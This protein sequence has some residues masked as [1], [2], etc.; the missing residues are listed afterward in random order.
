MITGT[1]EG[2]HAAPHSLLHGLDFLWLEITEKCNLSCTHCYA[3]SGPHLP[4]E[5]K[6]KFNDWR[7]VMDQAGR[8]GCRGV[9]FIG[10]EPTI[11]PDLS[12]LVRHAG[13]AGFEFCEV[14][15]NA[16]ALRS[17]LLKTLHDCG[18]RVA[19]SIY[20][21]TAEVHDRIT[22]RG[23]SFDRT[24]AG[25]RALVE[26]GIPTRAA[27][28]VM[29][30]NAAYVGETMELL[31][32]IGVDTMGTDVVRGLGRGFDR[33]PHESPEGEL[34]GACWQGRLC[35]DSQGDAFPCIFSKFIPVGNVFTH[36]L[37]EVV[38]GAPLSEFRQ[39]MLEDRV[40]AGGEEDRPGS[41]EGDDEVEN[42]GSDDRQPPP[43][44]PDGD[45]VQPVLNG[46]RPGPCQP[47]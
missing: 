46:C 8:L 19:F 20:C 38:A 27:V 47:G 44:L 2:S 31:E 30:E 25:I 34:C 12:R 28:I 26:L 15:T 32:R 29:G 23:G 22:G 21:D 14:Y 10:G 45:S 35:L 13:S 36:E 9:Q 24:I 18:A 4:L 6:M 16:T 41:T 40:G 7:R 11:H 33:A 43:C 17:E 3:D 5:R 1:S 37:S 42:T 39:R